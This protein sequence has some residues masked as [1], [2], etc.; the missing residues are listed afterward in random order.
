MLGVEGYKEGWEAPDPLALGL[1]SLNSMDHWFTA[2]TIGS[3]ESPGSFG[4]LSVHCL[5]D[6]LWVFLQKPLKRV[7]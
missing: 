4:T 7:F 1:L 2:W 5:K 3:L 6:L